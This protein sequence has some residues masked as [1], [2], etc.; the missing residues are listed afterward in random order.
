MSASERVDL[1]VIDA[2]NQF[3]LLLENKAGACHTQKQLEQYQES[4]KQVVNANP[5]LK[6]YDHA[7]IALDREFDKEV[8]EPRPAENAWLHL[9]YDW[10]KISASRALMHVKRGNAAASLVVSYCNRQTDWER[11]DDERC[12]E[13][14]AELHQSYPQAVKELISLSRGR[15]EREWLANSRREDAYSLFLLQNQGAVAL[16]RETQGMASVKAALLAKL[17]TL[18][19][20]NIRHKRSWLDMCPTDWQAF[21][22]SIWW[23]VFLNVSYS[24]VGRSKFTLALCW[25]RNNANTEEQGKQLRDLVATVENKFKKHPNSSWRRVVVARGLPLSE[26]CSQM[27]DLNLRLSQALA[28]QPIA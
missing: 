13:L 5:R 1:F 24:D 7:Y 12:L 21:E 6:N 26:L 11:P 16:L 9:G 2:Q 14:A 18:E 20:G 17:P 10:L 28:A 15:A 25:N 4:F 22:G 23:P 3:V 19:K 8:T 27:T